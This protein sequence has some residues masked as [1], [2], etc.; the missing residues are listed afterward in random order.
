MILIFRYSQEKPPF[1]RLFLFANRRSAANRI[2]PDGSA[3][4]GCAGECHH[5]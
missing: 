2:V 4:P 5:R 3:F 1:G